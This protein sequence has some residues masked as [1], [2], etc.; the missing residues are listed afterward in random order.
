S[1]RAAVVYSD[2]S[3]A[4]WD[5][6]DT[7]K[8]QRCRTVPA[9][10]AGV[11]DL[12][13]LSPAAAA[14]A[15]F[16]PDSFV[17]CASDSVLR[18]WSL[19]P[20]TPPKGGGKE[21]AVPGAGL[22]CHVA[23]GDRAGNLRIHRLGPSLEVVSFL[24]AHDAEVLSVDY[25]PDGRVVASAGRD[26][27]IHLFDAAD[28]YHLL[29]TLDE[30]ASAVTAVRFASRGRRLL[31]T[32]G[33][34]KLFE[35]SAGT[36]YDLAVEPSGRLAISAGQNRSLCVWDAAT[37]A[38]KRKYEA[39]A[40]VLS[41][42]VASVRIDPAGMFLATS[43]P[44]KGV[45]VHDFHSGEIVAE[46]FGHG[47]AVTAVAFAPDLLHLVSAS[48]D[49]CVMVWRLSAKARRSE[50]RG[51]APDTTPLST[52][53]STPRSPGGLSSLSTPAPRKAP[54]VSEL[55]RAGASPQP[56]WADEAPQATSAENKSQRSLL[57][58]LLDDT[59]R[60]AKGGVEQ[61]VELGADFSFVSE[62]VDTEVAR[63]GKSKPAPPKPSPSQ[64]PPPSGSGG[65]E[66]GRALAAAVSVGGMEVEDLEE[67][68]VEEEGGAE[69]E[70]VDSP[71][72][73]GE[74]REEAEEEEEGEY[75]V[76]MSQGVWR[77]TGVPPLGNTLA[78]AGGAAEALESDEEEDEAPSPA[79]PQVP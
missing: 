28:R 39:G 48:G 26:R 17:T 46:A 60:G 52:P 45:R 61:S 30:H 41:Q 11:W 10:A 71:R 65:G 24:E 44:D 42:R 16:P 57:N 5:I 22:R 37:G 32:G 21:G 64:T 54:G 74:G 6:R 38:R 31:S 15:G 35:V 69:V 78:S 66:G 33:D 34:K 43:S 68:E 47:E 49:G 7:S 58:A 76:I 53:L 18:V 63:F 14:S 12:E 25:S 8:V 73:V 1:Q 19:P 20:R 29:T 77:S 27:L 70:E 4:V 13:F 59:L 75:S 23:C 3:L 67:M 36:V 72:W 50:L 62:S 55:R 2:R 79:L 51:A 56:L 40:D 9:H